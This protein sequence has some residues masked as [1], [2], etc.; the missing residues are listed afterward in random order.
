VGE[1][2]GEGM[3]EVRAFEVDANVELRR[4]DNR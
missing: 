1:R 2:G 3:A 4:A